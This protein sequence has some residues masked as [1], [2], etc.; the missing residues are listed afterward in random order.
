VSP[1]VH[2][3]PSSHGVPLVTLV[4]T[5]PVAGSQVSIVHGLSSSQSTGVPTHMPAVVH[6]SSSVQALPSLQ[7]LPT[8]LGSGS[9]APLAVF[10]LHLRHWP[11][12]LTGP[13]WQVPF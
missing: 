2:G 9:Q 7:R 5:Q 3:L 12:F 13:G 11:Q 10:G 1:I 8:W 4:C 6:R